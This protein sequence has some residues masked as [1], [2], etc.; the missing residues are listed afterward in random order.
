LASKSVNFSELILS[1]QALKQGVNRLGFDGLNRL[2]FDGL[3][4]FRFDGLNHLG[5]DG[6]LESLWRGFS[7]VLDMKSLL[8]GSLSK[9]EYVNFPTEKH[10]TSRHELE[11]R[12]RHFCTIAKE[13]SQ[14]LSEHST[15]TKC[16]QAPRPCSES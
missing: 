12:R 6:L 9:M 5:F 2:R 11:E 13:R 7:N 15:T 3:N 1:I 16:N 14:L 8:R 10:N 4:R